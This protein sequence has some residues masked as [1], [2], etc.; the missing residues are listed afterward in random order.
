MARPP[1]GTPPADPPRRATRPAPA[2]APKTRSHVGKIAGA[3][4]ATAAASGVGTGL[5][6]AGHHPAPPPPPAQAGAACGGTERWNVKVAND[7]DATTIDANPKAASIV[8]MNALTPGP[9]D[10]GGR[11]GVEKAQYTV[12]GYLSFFKHEADGDYHVVITDDTGVFSTGKTAPNGHS[13]VVELPDPSCFAGK[14]GAGPTTSRLGQAIAEARAAFESQASHINGAGIPPKTIP[15]TVTGVA[16]FDFDHGQTGRAS[17]HPG[18]D[19]QGKVIE[20]HP[21]T[22]ISFDKLGEPD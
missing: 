1:S 11:M 15:V 4:I 8:Q 16:F 12:R 21:V 14:S 2:H 22:A 18:V 10:A 5:N 17:P 19:G 20:L 3:L 13:M 9:V 6:V 7:P